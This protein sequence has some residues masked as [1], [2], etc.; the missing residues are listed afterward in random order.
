MRKLTSIVP[1]ILLMLSVASCTKEGTEKFEGEY[2]FKMGGTLTL[3]PVDTTGIDT[4]RL[5]LASEMGQMKITTI[6]KEARLAIVTMDILGNGAVVLDATEN[7]GRLE[8]TPKERRTSIV[9]SGMTHSDADL[10][11]SGY[12][13]RYE[14]MIVFNMKYSGEYVYRGVNY[15]VTS[16][17]VDCIATMNE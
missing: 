5:S 7:D 4:M 17:Q 13:E 15:E 6:D 10:T 8:L 11:L 3:A 14:D 12:G 2:T 16:S 9:I 1:L